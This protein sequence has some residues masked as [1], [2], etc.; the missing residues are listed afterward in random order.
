MLLSYSQGCSSEGSRFTMQGILSHRK[1]VQKKGYD[2][3][4]HYLITSVQPV[5]VRHI[6]LTPLPLILSKVGTA[7]RYRAAVC[8]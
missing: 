5:I 8:L 1:A 4:P 3:P 6:H 2:L 7:A